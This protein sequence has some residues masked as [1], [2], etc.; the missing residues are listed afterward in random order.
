MDDPQWQKVQVMLIT[1]ALDNWKT[2]S[3]LTESSLFQ[4][5]FA[6]KRYIS[7]YQILECSQGEK[8]FKYGSKVQV[9]LIDHFELN[10][11]AFRSVSLTFCCNE[12]CDT[13]QVFWINTFTWML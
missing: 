4:L 13:V 10:L 3:S 2:E 5:M 1:F 11:L 12:G 8:M 7:F 9:L 6:Y